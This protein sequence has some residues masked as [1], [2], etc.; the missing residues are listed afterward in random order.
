[1][2]TVL[3]SNKQS[4]H[5]HRLVKEW[6]RVCDER[7]SLPPILH[8]KIKLLDSMI[9]DGITFS[10]E[11]FAFLAELL[12]LTL[13]SLGPDEVDP[14]AEQAYAKCAGEWAILPPWYDR[15]RALSVEGYEPY[16]G[17]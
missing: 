8:M 13:A 6:V 16:L 3:L 4:D 7:Q 2:P 10:D 5:V 14:L 9:E 15:Q 1:M 11:D 12:Q 17:T